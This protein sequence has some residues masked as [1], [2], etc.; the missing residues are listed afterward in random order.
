MMPMRGVVN[1]PLKVLQSL[2]TGTTVGVAH[3]DVTRLRLG[4]HFIAGFNTGA[5]SMTQTTGLV[6]PVNGRLG[7]EQHGTL[8]KAAVCC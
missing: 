1:C 8:T 3:G 5:E 7:P 4:R 2:F 6:E